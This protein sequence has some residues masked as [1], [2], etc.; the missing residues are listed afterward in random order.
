M[1]ESSSVFRKVSL[2]R[3]ASPEQLDQLL[4]V[5]D[6]RGWVGLS[7]IGL[8]LVVA[9]MW[10]IFGSI[11]E[12]VTGTGI[13]VRSG[14]VLEVTPVASGLITDVAVAVGETVVEGQVVA[15]LSQPQLSAQLH[16][17]TATLASLRERHEELLAFGSKDL[18]LQHAQLARQRSAVEEAKHG[19]RSLEH[20]TSE[21]LRI[22]EQLVKEGLML[23]QTL[24]ETREKQHQAIER[25]SDAKSQ[26]AQ[27]A[28]KELELRNRQTEEVAISQMKI[29]DAQRAVEALNHE[30]QSKTQVVSPYTGRVLELM[31]EQGI[32]AQAGEPIMR[33]DP[34][35][36][37]VQ[38]LEAVIYVPSYF[39]K[40]IRVGMSV[41]ITPATVKQEEFGMM[42]GKVS[43]VS[44]FPAT[45]KGM[46]RVL[47]NE[48]LVSSLAG[49]DA[50]YE[51]H[52]ELM[53]DPTTFSLYRWSSSQ[54][55]PQKI[56]SGTL[57]MANIAVAYR[58]PAELVLP[59]LRAY[60]G[61]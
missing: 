45:V 42:M 53:M 58:R 7:A 31:T 44:D 28:V 52:T 21:K 43:S 60:A 3:L 5:T 4:P 41:L 17:A 40:Q 35:G 25:M 18:A 20:E 59:M 15:R 54:G 11:P 9:V 27:I 50:P 49:S 57:A 19:A 61:R 36:R 24:L 14:G 46:Q 6:A 38:G 34:T 51:V 56:Q 8:A 16:Q 47:K 55:P 23:R 29:E 12:N 32:M 10:G 37:A 33:L 13:L 2:D 39:G 48:K 26:L 22:Q 1:N 30:L